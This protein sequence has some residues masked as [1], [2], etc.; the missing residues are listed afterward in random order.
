MA[1][2]SRRTRRR[3][4]V[5]KPQATPPSG[6]FLNSE[7]EAR[8]NADFVHRTIVE[9]KQFDP[10]FFSDNGLNITRVFRFQ[11]ILDFLCIKENIYPR[12]IRLFYDNL[13]HPLDEDG[14]T[15]KTRLV[16]YLNG[17]IIS[18]TKDD[19]ARIFGF[20]RQN[21]TIVPYNY[22]G[23]FGYTREKLEL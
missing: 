15:D 23:L 20:N 1:S 16:T 18:F 12:L 14:M 3:I 2:T 21:S 11:G 4:N 5:G 13:H 9:G 19:L 7:L 17:N 8:F 22:E 6:L 10:V